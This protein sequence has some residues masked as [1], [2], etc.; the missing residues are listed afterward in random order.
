MFQKIELSTDTALITSNPT[1]SGIFALTKFPIICHQITSA[2]KCNT[3]QPPKTELIRALVSSD[4][5]I[6]RITWFQIKN[7]F[8]L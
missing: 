6:F 5:I 4:W 2:Y 1:F 8:F 3:A 7:P